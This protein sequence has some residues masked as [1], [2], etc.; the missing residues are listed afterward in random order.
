MIKTSKEIEA[1]LIRLLRN[2]TDIANQITGDIYFAG[3]RPV[4]SKLEDLLISFIAGENGDIQE[5]FVNLLLF[6]PF[7][8]NASSSVPLPNIR[9]LMELER[10]LIDAIS[11]LTADKSNFLIRLRQ[12]PI[13]LEDEKL[14]QNYILARL[15]YKYID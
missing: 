12:T 4:D 5:G 2:H 9:R 3:T 1:D 11:I 6:V 15:N 13:S 8:W 7:I 14:G 10:L